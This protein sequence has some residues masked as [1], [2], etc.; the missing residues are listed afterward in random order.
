MSYIKSGDILTSGQQG[1][2]FGIKWDIRE[3]DRYIRQLGTELPLTI[4][5]VLIE[6]AEENIERQRQR[7]KG[8]SNIGGT[9]W[10]AGTSMKRTYQAMFSRS[11][12][13][14]NGEA[15]FGKSVTELIADSL[16]IG[17]RDYGA[18]QAVSVFSAPHPTGVIGSRK[19]KIALF[20]EG[21]VKPFQTKTGT[22]GTGFLHPGFPA[23]RFIE[24][25]GKNISI[26]F[27]DR[28]EL[29]AEMKLKPRGSGARR[30][31]LNTINPAEE[32]K[33]FNKFAKRWG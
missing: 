4:R 29:R 18:E 10:D 28:F 14:N 15:G 31:K 13:S 2:R 17:G 26:A 30:T 19:G 32:T 20:Y 8:M 24:H 23:L 5:E 7:L 3:L 1:T 6:L 12:R 21:G 11:Y 27:A 16:S 25:I 9:K 22:G 33:H